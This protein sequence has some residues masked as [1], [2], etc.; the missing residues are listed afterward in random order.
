M[1][2]VWYVTG[3]FRFPGKSVVLISAA[4]WRRIRELNEINNG[5][6]SSLYETPSILVWLIELGTQQQ[7]S[8]LI[9]CNSFCD[10]QDIFSFITFV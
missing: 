8:S 4:D 6:T 1:S 2:Q 10:F 5:N 9:I 7:L 3:S